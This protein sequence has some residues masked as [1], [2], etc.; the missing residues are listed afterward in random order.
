[1]NIAYLLSHDI[2]RNDGVTLKILTQVS[3][4]GKQGHNVKV[5]CQV[6]SKGDSILKANQYDVGNSYIKSR[7][8]SNK[9]LL[10]DVADFNPDVVYFRYDTYSQT[11]RTLLCKYSVV[12]EIN[13]NDLSEFY[14]LFKK[15]KT[16]KSFIRYMIYILFRG[17]I[18]NNVKGIVSVTKELSLNKNISKYNKQSIAI[19]NSINI[20][21][22]TTIKRP[23]YNRKG[24][25][26]IGTPNQPW[27]GVDFIEELAS[28]LTQIDF[29]IIGI[30]GRGGHNLHYH[31]Y[32]G[33]KEYQNIMKECCVC[34][35]S[36]AMYRNDMYE[37]NSLKV[38]EYI[39]GGFPVILGC[40][41]SA[42]IDEKQPHWMK[43][44]DTRYGLD[45]ESLE[46]FIDNYKDFVIPDEQKWLISSQYNEN[47]RLQFIESVVC[48]D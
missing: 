12:T 35:G 21:D 6:P 22:F 31:G 41:D 36:L 8:Y 5:F 26:F 10:N 27:H 30:E 48:S 23:G 16:V 39:A 20:D 40:K 2:T 4:W 28:N 3:E 17:A 18:F 33:R 43:I 13:T 42:Y 19:S 38:R 24:V 45:I 9:A 47:R 44:V 25:F 15:E 32:L 14:V 29:H 37:S 1:M 46:Q 11:I 34:I 7:L